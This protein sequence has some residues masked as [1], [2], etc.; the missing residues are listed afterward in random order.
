MVV[1]GPMKT[2]ERLIRETTAQLARLMGV[3]L[4]E[5]CSL[6]VVENA[7]YMPL[8]TVFHCTKCGQFHLIRDREGDHD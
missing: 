8:G 6:P 3:P 2:E 1:L 7:A 4:H 5:P